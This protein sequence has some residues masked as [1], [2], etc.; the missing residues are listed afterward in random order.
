MLFKG[1]RLWVALLLVGWGVYAA[2][3]L[4]SPTEPFASPVVIFTP[5]T[6]ALIK[7]KLAVVTWQEASTTRLS[8]FVAG[9]NGHLIQRWWDGSRWNW[10]DHGLPPGTLVASSPSAVAWPS[11]GTLRINVF[12]QGLN[13]RLIERY[14]DGSAW[15]WM[16][17]GLP[18]MK[19]EF[20]AV[21]SGGISLASA[22]SVITYQQVDGSRRINVFAKS[23]D[24][25]LIDRWWDGSRWNWTDHLWSSTSRIASAPVALQWEQPVAP[26]PKPVIR[27]NVFM[28]SFNGDL[29]E[30]WW[31]GSQWNWTSHGK[32]PASGGV[33]A[34][35][36]DPNGIAWK[37]GSVQYLNV[38]SRTA[39]GSLAE[40][41]FDG[42]TWN[43]MTHGRPPGKMPDGSPNALGSD[44]SVIGWKLAGDQRL[45]VFARGKNGNLVERYWNGALWLWTEHEVP[46]LDGRSPEAAKLAAAPAA[47]TWQLGPVTRANVFAAR[48]D[49]N[50]LERYWDGGTWAWNGQHG[51][52]NR[53]A[54]QPSRNASERAGRNR[55]DDKHE[56]LSLFPQWASVEP[57]DEPKVLEGV[58]VA[59]RISALDNPI[60]HSRDGRGAVVHDWNFMVAPDP[61]YQYLLSDANFLGSGAHAG[62]IEVEWEQADDKLSLDAIPGVGD[63]VWL[64]GRW[65]FDCGH[66]P[67]RTE[68]HPPTA[69]VV[70]RREPVV[71][72]DIFR[73]SDVPGR[74]VPATQ[75]V[76]RL[77][78]AGGPVDF[79]GTISLPDAEDLLTFLL[80]YKVNDS[81][82][83][84]KLLPSKWSY[85]NYVR[86]VASSE[87]D[88]PLPPRPP[89]AAQ[90]SWFTI[91][92]VLGEITAEPQPAGSPTRYRVKI[93]APGDG[94]RTLTFVAYWS[95]SSGRGV[96]SP[97]ARK[98]FVGFGSSI[99]KTHDGRKG[100]MSWAPAFVPGGDDGRPEWVQYFSANGHWIRYDPG[101]SSSVTL[102][103]DGDQ[104]LRISAAGYEC[105]LSCGEKWDDDLT[106][107]PNDRIGTVTQLFDSVS[108]F[109]LGA[110]FTVYSQ[111]VTG[112]S[113]RATQGTQSDYRLS[114]II[115]PR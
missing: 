103:V 41:W 83:L 15:N 66:P 86:T 67:Y 49:G 4:P 23:A 93:P 14:W 81:I 42:K 11:G 105:D 40:R 68:I 32:P 51:P 72:E 79:K 19:R 21:Q 85:D 74:P 1:M 80:D 37:A 58:V 115:A 97:T 61:D 25:R 113:K 73:N 110:G 13:G 44:F 27:I 34:N 59:S 22:P 26:F 39:G 90:P 31:D 28:T 57:S 46:T 64:R 63:R 30:R 99:E 29:I 78:G 88:V 60:N 3:P 104:T 107:S 35:L 95:D 62:T 102:N 9:V 84:R 56:I 71:L 54:V 24:G 16:D 76:V 77:S 20:G 96:S 75:A 38:F 65:I 109:G 18:P 7:G 92:G 114:F 43:W 94:S 17:H 10:T 47:F 53:M 55:C 12:F 69:L 111:P 8:L 48:A 101:R 82:D 106:E 6:P 45:N 2:E 98:L 91:G 36:S 52:S 112:F 33:Q 5:G 87:F 70:I 89:G 50:L 100:L 108:S